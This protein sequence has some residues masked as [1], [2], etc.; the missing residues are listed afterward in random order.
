MLDDYNEKINNYK[1][2]SLNDFSIKAIQQRPNPN[3]EKF[4]SSQQL[5]EYYKNM[6]ASEGLIKAIKLDL[7][8]TDPG[9]I[10]FQKE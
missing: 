2:T 6:S 1:S 3:S 4:S 10:I 9:N 7:N 5:F 8:R